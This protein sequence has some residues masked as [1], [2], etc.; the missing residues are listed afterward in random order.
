MKDEKVT[1]DG[2]QEIL[3]LERPRRRS[4]R[5]IDIDQLM[6][7]L[8]AAELSGR[9]RDGGEHEARSVIVDT[10]RALVEVEY[11]RQCGKS[12]EFQRAVLEALRRRE[13]D[14]R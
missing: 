11:L 14:A 9:I 6:E 10:V 12:S 1:F 3:V 13:E 2:E 4:P 5:M 8:E 7:T